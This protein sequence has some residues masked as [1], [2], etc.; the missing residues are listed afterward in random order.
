MHLLPLVCNVL[1]REGE[2]SIF[3]STTRTALTGG[4]RGNK[5]ESE[6]DL[7]LALSKSRIISAKWFL[8]QTFPSLYA[9]RKEAWFR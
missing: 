4:P 8:H 2:V 5:S 1:L 7:W 6:K 3:N 9:T